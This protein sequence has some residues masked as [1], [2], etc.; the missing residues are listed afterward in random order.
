LATI[1]RLH[2]LLAV[3]SSCDSG[4]SE[5]TLVTKASQIV[6][7][8]PSVEADMTNEEVR[9]CLS[10]ENASE[11]LAVVDDQ[12]RPI[13]LINRSI[14][15]EAYSRPYAREIFGRRSC[16]AWMDK[17]ALIIDADTPIEELVRLA[18]GKGSKVLK[19]G[20]ITTQDGLYS[21]L[22]TGFSLMEAMEALEAEK[23]RQILQSIDYAS[24]IQ[25]SHLRTSQEHLAASLP[26]QALIWQ[27]RDVVGGD[28][29]FFRRLPEGLFMALVD[30]TGHGVPGAFMT[31]IA[32]SF[33]EQ[34]ITP[35]T[36]PV[37]PGRVLTDLNRYIKQVLAQG[38][39]AHSFEGS[40]ATP[41]SDD[42]M[43]AACYLLANDGAT[44]SFASARLS[45]FLIPGGSGELQCLEGERAGIG[46]VDTPDGATW[47]TC[48]LAMDPG[49]RVLCFTDGVTDQLGGPKNIA[50]GRKRLGEWFSRMASCPA[51]EIADDFQ[52]FFSDWQ[53][54]QTRRDDLSLFVFTPE[55]NP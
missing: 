33:L 5:K 34:R 6:K 45:L 53:G 41:R 9:Q 19:D 4:A 2:E 8:V 50:L 44:L 46:Y 29:Y 47:Q 43:D 15:L 22:G 26:D 3:A 13:G 28:C 14:F 21:G 51:R 49:S 10:R 39:Q 1:E 24:T 54:R 48:Q 7:R 20:F 23:S 31:L 17:D 40:A 30:C 27:P 38:N 35:E 18:V 55:L 32:L 11:A 42:G 52:S 12:G 36:S 25:R 37:D 16:I